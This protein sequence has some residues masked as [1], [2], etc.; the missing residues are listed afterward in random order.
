[1]S[2]VLTTNPATGRELASYTAMTDTDIDA[3]LNR[4]EKAQRH[5]A[6]RTLDQRAEVISTAAQLLRSEAEELSLL[7]TREMGKPL[8]GVTRGDRQMR[9]RARLLRRECATPARRYPL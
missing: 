8:Q 1:M 5:W 3:A 2:H 9:H 7:M 6:E 4:S